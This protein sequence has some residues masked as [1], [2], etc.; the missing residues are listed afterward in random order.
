MWMY[1]LRLTGE[2]W[3]LKMD[4]IINKKECSRKII[5]TWSVV[6][7]KIKLISKGFLFNFRKSVITTWG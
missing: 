1:S 2:Q 6:C 7:L 3:Y 4:L 5:I